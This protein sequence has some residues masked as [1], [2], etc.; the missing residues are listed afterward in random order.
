MTFGRMLY[1]DKKKS[2][3][4]GQKNWSKLKVTGEGH[5]G[6]I[7][8]KKWLFMLLAQWLKKLLTDFHELWQ[9]GVE[10]Q[11]EDYVQW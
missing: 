11:K 10:W 9:D 7:T 3:L 2:T 8:V 4:N 5:R 1:N 6:Q